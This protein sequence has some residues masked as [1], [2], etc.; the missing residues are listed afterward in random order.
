MIMRKITSFIVLLLLFAIGTVQAEVTQPTLTTDPS[1]PT[2]YTIQNCR[3]SKYA[4][5]TG[6]SSQLRQTSDIS[7]KT[8]WYFMANGE[9]VSIINAFNPAVKAASINRFTAEGAVW[10]LVENPFQAGYFCV[11]LTADAS[12]NCWDDF[13]KQA[14]VIDFWA[15]TSSDYNGDSWT[16]AETSYTYSE[17]QDMIAQ[18]ESAN[19]PP[20]IS[21]DYALT[22]GNAVES[23]IPVTDA[24]DNTHWYVLTQKRD[25][26]SPVYDVETG[27]VLMRDVSYVTAASLT[28]T[29]VTESAKYLVRFISTGTDSLYYIQFAN[30]NYINSSLSTTE[31]VDYA[32]IFAFYNSNAGSGSYFGWNLETTKGK[33]V[34]SRGPYVTINF[35]SSGLVSGTSSSSNVW[36]LYETT[37]EESPFVEYVVKDTEGNTLFTSPP[38]ATAV[39]TTITDLLAKYQL[40]DFYT[41]STVSQTI[42]SL[43]TTT[44]EFTA[45][46]RDD[47]IVQY[48]SNANAPFYY[49]VSMRSKFLSYDAT[50]AGHVA[51]SETVDDTDPNALWAFVG[52]PYKG[53]HVYNKAI[54]ADSVLTYTTVVARSHK[55]N[56]IMFVD[57][58]E[59]ADNL[60]TIE[61]NSS[62]FVLRMKLDPNIYFHYGVAVGSV[63]LR[64]CSVAEWK[65][66]HTDVGSTF[67]VYEP[68][69]Y[70]SLFHTM[71]EPYVTAAETH[72]G[73]YFQLA[74]SGAALD[75]FTTKWNE[76]IT[77]NQN[78]ID[79]T[80]TQ[81]NE[82]VAAFNAA[83]V[84]PSDGYY[85]IKSNLTTDSYGYVGVGDDAVLVGNI[86][87]PATNASTV[88]Y[89][90]QNGDTYSFSTEG[91]YGTAV[92]QNTAAQV[93]DTEHNFTLASITPGSAY[94]NTNSDESYSC[95]NVSQT[96][97]Y[98]IIGWEG[99][100]DASQFVFEDAT[101]VTLNLHNGGDGYY[102]ATTYLPFDVTLPEGV[103]AY[104]MTYY[105]S[106]G[107]A[108][109]TEIGQSLPA[110][111]PALLKSSSVSS[112]TAT[113]TS[114]LT[115]SDISNALSGTYFST[116]LSDGQYSLGIANSKVGFYHLTDALS[117]NRA[118]LT[119]S[120]GIRAIY[121]EEDEVTGIGHAVAGDVEGEAYDL[122]GR[123]V[124]TMQRNGIYIINGKKVIK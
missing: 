6:V 65:S 21:S 99:S 88:F 42:S 29:K 98:N 83:L 35:N 82:A 12:A 74:A 52:S 58:A 19:M 120:S 93:D 56:N 23:F 123:R 53:F 38:V 14:S 75:T 46:K 71:V 9:G 22:V 118:Y 68:V 90:K 7:S 73:E 102:Y 80:R 44:I 13:H 86:S 15:P 78:D 41:Y 109:I 77:N 11:S 66:V 31:L 110:G 107:V 124:N 17:V 61:S 70:F 119:T 49:T 106:E 105:D 84:M 27:S 48:T 108:R 63:Y 111:T 116:T 39:G 47:P 40:T 64:T 43:G 16:I 69:D 117:A 62:G 76:A 115:S 2:Y 25:S 34:N 89:V 95:Y 97:S 112:A 57:A 24:S 85:R 96:Q 3:S 28:G 103:T 94:I 20:V 67:V 114:G 59:A 37:F 87:S 33:R 32:A 1:N 30:G 122:Q 54:G 91:A 10:Y 121:F 101:T 79:M 113:I 26:E 55:L 81:Y 5:Y 60:W 8:L 36:T 72:A 100:D 50:A 4:L 104:A 51:F 92:S 18:E 45:T